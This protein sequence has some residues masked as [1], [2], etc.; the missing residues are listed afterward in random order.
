MAGY[1][2]QSDGTYHIPII[3]LGTRLRD[4]FG[5]TIKE[6]SHFDTVDDVHAPNSYHDFDEAI[7]VQDWRDDTIDGVSW[8]KRTGNLENLLH[9][10]GVEVIGPNSGVAGHERHLHL[11]AKGGI[12]KLNEDQYQY[13]FG[14]QSG[15]K[16]STF[17]HSF[18]PPDRGQTPSSTDKP[19]PTRQDGTIQFSQIDQTQQSPEQ[20]AKA[21][22]KAYSEMSKSQLDSAYDSLRKEDP[23][24]A[25]I[26]G[27]IMH[28]AYFGK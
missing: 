19:L 22:A 6:H 13:L 24:K 12:F 25:S 11:A 26:E 15:G 3:D 27:K 4:N 18:T 17:S 2:R 23:A 5:L 20:K 9:G 28:K 1:T 7:D 14:G 16:L 10:S 21:R 8:Q